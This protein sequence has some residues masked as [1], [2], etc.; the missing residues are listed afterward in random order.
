MKKQF[1]LLAAIAFSTAALAQVKPAAG[2]RAGYVSSSI[3]GEA[4]QNLNKLIDIT[5]GAITSGN[6]SGLFAGGYV[7]VPLTENISL[8]PAVYYAQKG[9]TLNGALSIKGADFLGA[10]ARASL[11]LHYIDVPVVLKGTVGGFQVF[12]G[13]Q[14]SYLAKADLRTVAG[15]LGFNVLDRTIDASRQFNRWDAGVTG[16]IGYQF[17]N[18]LNVMAAYDHGLSRADANRNLNSYN[19]SFKVGLGFTF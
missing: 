1:L 6:H 19:R 17:T 11:N 3:K 16:G 2:V 9:Y 4:V 14:V 8:E 15:A 7:A 5:N 18:G 13:P 10:S 12:A